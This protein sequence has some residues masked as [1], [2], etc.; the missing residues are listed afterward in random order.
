MN[1]LVIING[2][3]KSI[4]NNNNAQTSS[5]SAVTINTMKKLN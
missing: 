3:N 1:H 5:P 4:L 2:T